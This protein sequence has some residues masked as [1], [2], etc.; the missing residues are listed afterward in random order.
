ML[1]LVLDGHAVDEAFGDERRRRTG[2][3]MAGAQGV[4]DAMP[5]LADVAAGGLRR[6][7]GEP[8]ARGSSMGERVVEIVDF[9]G[10]AGLP[11]RTQQPQ[12]L[13]VAD[14]GE[15][16]DER[17]HQAGVLGTQR[18]V[19]EVLDDPERARAHLRQC[20]DDPC[21]RVHLGAPALQALPGA[22][23]LMPGGGAGTHSCEA[24][25]VVGGCGR[26]TP[27]HG[28]VDQLPPGVE[29]RPGD[30]EAGQGR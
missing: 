16:P 28:P 22:A 21:S 2:D 30:V 20:V 8:S 27:A 3:G 9:R 18:R 6:Q 25:R 17:G 26:K 15:V 1:V 5:D 4:E 14:V 24:A 12:V 29:V 19:V 13:V 23:D 11:Q 7:Q 10:D